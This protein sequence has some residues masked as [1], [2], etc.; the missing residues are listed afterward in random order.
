MVSQGDKAKEQKARA[1]NQIR[2]QEHAGTYYH[3]PDPYEMNGSNDPSGLP[4]GSASLKHVVTKNIESKREEARRLMGPNE[5]QSAHEVCSTTRYDVLDQ[6]IPQPLS[7]SGTSSGGMSSRQPR[8]PDQT[9]P[10]PTPLYVTAKTYR[11][12][13]YSVGQLHPE[14][15]SSAAPPPASSSRG[16]RM[17]PYS[18]FRKR[19]TSGGMSSKI[20]KEGRLSEADYYEGQISWD[21]K[22]GYWQP[23]EF[24]E[25]RGG[26]TSQQK[27]THRLNPTA[28]SFTPG[29]I[30]S[31]GSKTQKENMGWLK[32][33]PERHS[34]ATEGSQY[35]VIPAT[36]I[37]VTQEPNSQTKFGFEALQPKQDSHKFLRET[38]E[39]L[40]KHE[41]A[42]LQT[43]PSLFQN[44]SLWT[45]SLSSLHDKHPQIFSS[46]NH[47]L[48][49]R[50][51]II[52]PSK[53][54]DDTGKSLLTLSWEVN[55][56]LKQT[57]TA[58][59]LALDFQEKITTT[60]FAVDKQIGLEMSSF[61]W[62]CI[63]LLLLV[64]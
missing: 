1:E 4:W 31:D 60:I 39:Q 52:F 29:F 33:V 40:S 51:T 36:D 58:W 54:S 27:G 18:G 28:P 6:N 8:Q 32:P 26:A 16:G 46:L 17:L 22:Y 55:F 21:Q 10:I 53:V 56:K 63:W 3:T 30:R 20:L 2:N 59:K 35:T 11:S 7:S 47:E 24:E 45:K 49:K 43:I 57:P 62:N 9:N 34:S 42:R 5:Y 13:S 25:S 50:T 41:Q 61:A 19:P 14:S 12:Q 15:P 37:T 64:S 23:H 38:I 44:A 48:A